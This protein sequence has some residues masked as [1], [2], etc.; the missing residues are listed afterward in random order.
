M[1]F[2]GVGRKSMAAESDYESV[3]H[4]V[5]PQLSTSI[6]GGKVL[7]ERVNEVIKFV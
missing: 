1:V 5:F 2:L 3:W 6:C 7:V 4:P